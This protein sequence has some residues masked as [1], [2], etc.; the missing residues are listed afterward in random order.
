MRE[1]IAFEREMAALLRPALGPQQ[2]ELESQSPDTCKA[3]WEKF[4]AGLPSDVQAALDPLDRERAVALA[5]HHGLRDVTALTNM[6]FFAMYG[7]VHGYCKIKGDTRVPDGGD[8]YK[9]VWRKLQRTHVLPALARP[10]PKLAK[11][12]GIKCTRREVRVADPMPDNPSVDITGRY[13]HVVKSGAPLFALRINQAGRHIECLLRDIAV[14]GKDGHGGAQHWLHGDIQPDGSFYVFDRNNPSTLA[15]LAPKGKNRLELSIDGGLTHAVER[16]SAEPTLLGPLT[17]LGPEDEFVRLHEQRPLSNA[18]RRHL[19]ASLAADR[20]EPFLRDFFTRKSSNLDDVLGRVA[21]AKRL[22]DYL[23]AVFQDPNAGV[24]MN[25][26]SD[27]RLARYYARF[28]LAR[29]KWKWRYISSHLDFIQMMYN[30]VKR[31]GR[32]LSGGATSL[33]M[34]ELWL[35]LSEQPDGPEHK[36]K[37]ELKLVGGGLLVHGY[38]GT[39]M[40]EKVSAGGRWAKGEKHVFECWLGGLEWGAGMKILD[41]YSGVATSPFEW[42]PP[43]FPGPIELVEAGAGVSFGP[44]GVDASAGFMLIQGSGYKPTLR[45]HFTEAGFTPDPATDFKRDPDA[46]LNIKNIKLGAKIGPSGIWGSI[47]NKK[48]RNVDYST[49]QAKTDYAVSHSLT[50]DVHFCLDSAL[51]TEDARQALRIMCARELPGFMSRESRLTIHGH[52]DLS[53]PTA[54]N[55]TLSEL[56]ARNTLQAIKE[57]LGEKRFAL[58]SD[59]IIAIGKGEKEARPPD[60]NPDHRRVDVILNA[61]LVLTLRAA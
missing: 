27:Q 23:R 56:R 20:I 31:D 11:K 7:S 32:S 51:L 10:S 17:F 54:H 26:I 35:G 49:F 45:V 53:G 33:T 29:N 28:L 55:Q 3:R 6:L 14:P 46:P 18:Q 61:R 16:T 2:S 40:V 1:R 52:T 34:M 44:V 47:R 22:D 42:Q 59:R 4:R 58:P 8:K 21:S 5:V 41:S 24:S 13:E 37:I 9:D 25:V 36:Y 60:V 57:I 38:I 43:D 19:T 15:R 39:M 30:A 48:F 12:G 50:E